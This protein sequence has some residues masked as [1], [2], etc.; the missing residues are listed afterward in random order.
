MHLDRHCRRCVGQFE[1]VLGLIIAVAI[2]DG[3]QVACAG[4]ITKL[5]L[6]AGWRIDFSR[7]VDRIGT[8]LL[9]QHL[10]QA[11][12]VGNSVTILA[13]QGVVMEVERIEFFLP[14]SRLRAAAGH[15]E[16]FSAMQRQHVRARHILGKGQGPP[17]A[18]TAILIIQRAE[19]Q[20][21]W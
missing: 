1:Q 11:G 8:C 10:N 2:T 13:F 9:G 4:A 12:L 20:A 14:D 21:Q 15:F 16:R 18:K 7:Q 3:F 19:E 17:F 6:V 5:N